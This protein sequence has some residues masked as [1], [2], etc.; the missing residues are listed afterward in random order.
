[1]NTE[2][3]KITAK[4][5]ANAPALYESLAVRKEFENVFKESLNQTWN[6]E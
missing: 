1:M 3:E 4:I 5:K 2:S 6:G